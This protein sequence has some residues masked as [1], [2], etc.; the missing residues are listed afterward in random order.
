MLFYPS[1]K[2]AIFIDGANLYG[3]AKGLA[4]DIDYR[5]LLDLFAK[6]SQLVRAFYYTALPADDSEF[7][8]IRPLVDWLSFN[9]FAVVTKPVR[10]FTDHQG[11]RR[12]KGN[13][14]GM[15]LAVDAMDL[16]G[17]VDHLVIISGDGD[18]RC[19]VQSLQRRGKRVTIVSTIKTTPPM[20]AE[21]LR[22]QAD[23]FVDL[24]DLQPQIEKPRSF[25]QPFCKP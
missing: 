3:M 4:F 25:T 15:E 5:K 16:A 24:A 14:I 22:R 23:N 1:E 10:E 8:A 7:A 18:F 12:T 6:K 19:L 11:H 21:E 13:N 20:C 2:L 17:C 9:G